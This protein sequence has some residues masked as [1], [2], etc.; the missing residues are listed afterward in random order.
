RV[1]NAL[2]LQLTDELAQRGIDKVELP[3]EPLSRRAD[4]ISVAA[5][6]TGDR[7]GRQFLTDTD[8]L[9][10]GTEQCRHTHPL[11]AVMIVAVD[12]VEH[13]LNVQRVVALDVIEAVGPTVVRRRIGEWDGRTTGKRQRHRDGVDLR[14]VKVLDTLAAR[15]VRPLIRRMLVGPGRTATVLAHHLEY[16]VHAQV[17]MRL[18]GAAT[19]LRVA[20]Q[21]VRVQS[22]TAIEPGQ[23]LIDS[24]VPGDIRADR[25]GAGTTRVPQ[26]IR[27][28]RRRERTVIGIVVPQ[29]R[30]DR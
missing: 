27:H 4:G 13:R 3:G 28:R 26:S 8:S 21:E 2:L 19:V 25:A 22:A 20:H 7:I 15:T 24:L 23:I 29:P 9:E 16:S 12:L 10:V 1:V 5:L 11:R 14:T 17:L 6:G 30:R 18:N